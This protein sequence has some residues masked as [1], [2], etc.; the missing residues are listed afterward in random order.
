MWFRGLLAIGACLLA[1]GH[2]EQA[3][4]QGALVTPAP[5]GGQ[6][7]VTC[8]IP[9]CDQC[10]SSTLNCA[11]CGAGTYTFLEFG[12]PATFLKCYNCS[13]INCANDG[14]ADNV[15]CQSCP[16]GF[17]LSKVGIL[18]GQG[19]YADGAQYSPSN[20][21]CSIQP[22]PVNCLGARR[23]GAPPVPV[24]PNSN[25]SPEPSDPTAPSP[26]GED[27]APAPSPPLPPPPPTPEA[28]TSTPTQLP[29][30]PPPAPPLTAQPTSRPTA[31]EVSSPTAR[32][33]ATARPTVQPPAEAPAPQPVAEEADSGTTAEAPAPASQPTPAPS[34][35]KHQWST[36]LA[37]AVLAVASIAVL[38]A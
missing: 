10:D 9:G 4:A 7:G 20:V 36:P 16:S 22:C 5:G 3:A 29:S 35:A 15:G 28:P 33:V 27:A 14:C 34:A 19:E 32:P 18:P 11:N 31:G 23:P 12:G 8:N 25:E 17:A 2:L 21:D 13:E 6:S 24:T 30:P 37:A 1:A 26:S 38:L